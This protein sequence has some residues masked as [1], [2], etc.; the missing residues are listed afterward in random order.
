MGFQNEMKKDD[1]VNAKDVLRFNFASVAVDGFKLNP[2]GK[3]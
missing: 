3:L 1:F 2:S